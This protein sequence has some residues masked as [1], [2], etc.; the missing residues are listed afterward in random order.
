VRRLLHVA[1]LQSA[2]WRTKVRLAVVASGL[3]A[4]LFAIPIP[5][6]TNSEGVIWLPD[7]AY[8][9]A[10]ADGF[11]ERVLT[12]S[13][14]L[15]GKGDLLIESQDSLLGRQ[16]ELRQKRVQELE[17]RLDAERFADR[18][19]AE[20]TR[21][22]LA[23]EQARLVS[24]LEKQDRLVARSEREGT[25]L[26]PRPADLPGRFFR[27]GETLAYVLP[28][29]TNVIRCIVLQDNIDLVRHQLRDVQVRLASDLTSTLQARIVREVPAAGDEVPSKAL[30]TGGG[31]AIA[32]DPRDSNGMKVV[33]RLFQFDLELERTLINPEFGGRAYIR[34]EHQLEPLASQIYR[35]VRQLFLSRFNA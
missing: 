23:E 15:V 32:S 1:E 24:D 14:T 17:L 20:I 28:G 6:H 16:I 7:N 29:Q 2:G 11:I 30:S 34:F 22:D 4:A 19:L 12:G 9:R 18:A 27:K 8:V 35:R 10:G 31:G 26:L 13:G 33:R 3:A 21:M 25:F 5:L